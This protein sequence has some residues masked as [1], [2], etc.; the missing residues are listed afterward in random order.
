MARSISPA[1]ASNRIT[2][3][4]RTILTDEDPVLRTPS[5][6]VDL[7]DP[8]LDRDIAD[9]AET[10]RD[11][12]ERAGFGRAI[13]APQ[14]GITKRIIVMNLGAGPLAMINPV[15]TD[16]SEETQ[17]VWD[18]CLSVPDRLVQVERSVSISLTYR[19][20]AGL[21]IDWRDLPADMSE[22]LQHE[23]D[24]LDGVLMTDRADAPDS[25]RPLTE[26]ESLVPGFGAP[27]SRI[28]AEAIAANAS[29]IDP[30]FTDSPQFECEPLSVELGCKVTLKVETLNPIRCFKGRGASLFVSDHVDRNGSN[31]PVVSASA[32]NWGQAVAYACRTTGT[33]FTVFASEAANPAKVERMKSLGAEVILHGNDFDGSKLAAKAYAAERSLHFVEDS[34]DVEVT[35]GHGS[36]ALELFD[37]VAAA[38]DHLD[39]V[40]VPLGNGAMISGIG[41]WARAASPATKVIG[42]T[43]TGAPAMLSAWR[44]P[45]DQES[46]ETDR[47]DTIADG[48]A[49]RVPVPDA[50]DDMRIVVDDIKPVD[51]DGITEAMQLLFRT[52]GLITEPAGASAIAAIAANRREFAGRHVAVVISGSN[53]APD[54][55]RSLASDG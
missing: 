16:H 51:D 2:G 53:I 24:H 11:F 46:W 4:V 1:N 40:I 34:Q 42:V 18:D 10:L 13:S 52:A 35:V 54:L 32:G 48:L 41:C 15:I 21:E 38:G 36:L 14:I 20:R 8:E 5:T 12:R 7:A 43:P 25:V 17:M 33:P 49:V 23:C 27:R 47:L 44:N 29:R 39:A 45:D 50:V 9:L 22:L 30:V 28:T 55:L 3:R 6:P 37:A 19:D 31:A 26:R